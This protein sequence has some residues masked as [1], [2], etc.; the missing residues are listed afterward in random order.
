[1]IMRTLLRPF[2]IH[3]AYSPIETIV[4]FSIIGTLAYFQLLNTIKHSAFLAQ[5]SNFVTFGSSP[6]VLRPSYA[7]ATEE[8]MVSA[9]ERVWATASDDGLAKA[10]L[11]QIVWEV[12]E[13][14]ANR[15]HC[16]QPVL[17]CSSIPQSAPSS[18]SF[19]TS[20]DLLETVR[21]ISEQITG[22]LADGKYAQVCY[23]PAPNDSAT[24][25]PPCFSATSVTERTFTQTLAFKSGARE[26]FVNSLAKFVSSVRHRRAS[27][28][29]SVFNVLIS[30]FSVYLVGS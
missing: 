21:G 14:R 8:D 11:Q 10:E 30:V 22:S 28:L 20:S 18:L 1:M 17:Q 24:A 16:N 15:V 19:L 25:P 12:K 13:V 9:P 5:G 29:P 2:A 4:F 26:E 27:L 23:R 7:L 3:A 6:Q